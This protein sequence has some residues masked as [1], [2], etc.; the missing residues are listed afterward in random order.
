MLDEAEVQVIARLARI[1]INDDES[2][3]LTLQLSRI[4]ALV[5]EM[6]KVDTER[7]EPLAHPLELVARRRPDVVTETDQRA[8]M[9]QTA[10]A[11][12]DGYYLVPRVIE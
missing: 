10:P 4:L 5:A 7:V 6:N 12:H 8:T 11:T 3:T 9:Q 2:P 1:G